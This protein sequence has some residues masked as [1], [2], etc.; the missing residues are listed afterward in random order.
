MKLTLKILA[1]L[2]VILTIVFVVTNIISGNIFKSIFLENKAFSMADHASKET[3]E[4]FEEADFAKKE[5]DENLR[6][7]MKSYA[8]ALEDSSIFRV[9][10]W[11]RN[12]QIAYS[13]LP[14]EIGSKEE[15]FEQR[16][17]EVFQSH[18]PVF[19]K[20]KKDNAESSESGFGTFLQ[21]M[22]PIKDFTGETFYV[23]EAHAATSAILS[24]IQSSINKTIYLLVGSGTIIFI[25]FYIL[26]QIFI[27]RPVM[28]LSREMDSVGKGDFK[29][30]VA[31]KSKDEI[32]N[33]YK[34]FNFMRLKLNEF[35]EKLDLSQN[36]L[37]DQL[38]QLEKFQKL[39]VDRELKMIELKKELAELRKD[40]G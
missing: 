11:D 19:W 7:K 27:V 37:E 30:Q 28:K 23:Y 5:V 34:N 25:T 4:I 31:T 9:K 36:K 15:G 2:F 16:L 24:G 39:T 29:R 35:F 13:D 6:Q 17:S 1:P 26:L 12:Y 3:R 33:L 18:D 8:K 20:L 21:V 22:V 14:S 40:R 10:I 32:G 38:V